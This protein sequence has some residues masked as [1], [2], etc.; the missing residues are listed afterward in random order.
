MA[1]SSTRCLGAALVLAMLLAV[2]GA[3]AQQTAPAHNKGGSK[4]LTK[5][6][7]LAACATCTKSGR[8]LTCLSCRGGA[9]LV[10]GRC[11]CPAGSGRSGSAGTARAGAST[12]HSKNGGGG[13]SS[14]SR[15]ANG[16][17]PCAD[18]FYSGVS[19]AVGSATCLRCPQ[20][21]VR[22]AEGTS[23]LVAAG[24]YYNSASRVVAACSG[25]FFI[26]E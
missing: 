20:N 8:S 13:H 2:A 23:C 17:S 12:A 5:C 24:Y 26:F 4:T 22:N 11:Q 25:E 3:A 6:H 16:C 10:N 1:R 21:T 7:S 15:S 14:S 19:R 9:E 18:G